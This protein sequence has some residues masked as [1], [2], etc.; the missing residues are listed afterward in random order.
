MLHFYVRPISVV[1]LYVVRVLDMFLLRHAIRE[2]GNILRNSFILESSGSIINGPGHGIS[3]KDGSNGADKTYLKQNNRVIGT[4][5]SNNVSMRMNSA[6][7]ICE[8][9]K[10]FKSNCFAE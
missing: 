10:E 8:K 4:E 2:M 3:K 5:E 1:C 6:S 7:I 9:N